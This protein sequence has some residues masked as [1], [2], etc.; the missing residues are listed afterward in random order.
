MREL[1][2]MSGSHLNNFRVLIVPGLHGSGPDHWQTRWEQLFPWFERV[3]QEHWDVPDIQRWSGRVDEALQK[4]A[5]PTL[6]IAHSF[7]CLASVHAA[8]AGIPHLAG[9]L[10]VAPADPVKFGIVQQMQ[11]RRLSC[12]A[13]VV[14]SMNDPWMGARQAAGWA[15]SWHCDFINAGA[16]GHINAESRLGNWEYGL[17]LISLLTSE[18]VQ[19][20]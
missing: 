16:L 1:H 18:V 2:E 6:L 14:G 13:L 7:G 4:F 5:R 12:P 15:K 10:L 20:A 8:S 17:S 11:R 3:E 19:S 9:A